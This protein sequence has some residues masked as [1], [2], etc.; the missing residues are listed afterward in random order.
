MDMAIRLS[1]EKDAYI[2]KNLYPL[3]LHDLSEQNGTLPNKHGIYEESD[4]YVTLNDQCEVLNIWW[5]KPNALFP[6]LILVDDNPAGFIFVATPPYCLKG[7]DYFL[8]E[9][10]LLRP[11]RGK[12]IAEEAVTNV[13]DRFKGK[14]GLF[15]CPSPD[16]TGE[17]FWRKTVSRY[18]NGNF[19]EEYEDTIDGNKLVFRFDNSSF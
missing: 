7:N 11:Y 14:W 5:T 16:V 19:T 6:F 15:T 1:T 10:F 4:E 18:S 12:G 2:I 13:F 17:K 8:N 3:Y 9:I